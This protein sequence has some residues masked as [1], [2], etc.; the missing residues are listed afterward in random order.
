MAL[1]TPPYKIK[2]KGI[3]VSV[4]LDEWVDI[5]CEPALDKYYIQLV[6]N[7]KMSINDIKTYVDTKILKKYNTKLS[8]SSKS[9]HVKY[10]YEVINSKNKIMEVWVEYNY[11]S[12]HKKWRCICDWGVDKTYELSPGF[13]LY[14]Y[15]PFR[16]IGS[17]FTMKFIILR[18]D[19]IHQYL[20]KNVLNES[21]KNDINANN[22]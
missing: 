22:I 21:D 12:I 9:I 16:F 6:F 3:Y 11:D 5:Y 2:F 19:Y 10:F 20:L 1:L 4:W 7:S 13:A 14:K 18:S 15:L 17:L 8:K